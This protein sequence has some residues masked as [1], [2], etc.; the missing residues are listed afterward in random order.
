MSSYI[1]QVN[2][3]I[4]PSNKH[5]MENVPDTIGRKFIQ[6]DARRNG[7]QRTC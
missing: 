1:I 3:E 2:I 4:Q 6:A 5:D 7:R